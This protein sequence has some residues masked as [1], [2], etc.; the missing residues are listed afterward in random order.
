MT[1]DIYCYQE[2]TKG[3]YLIVKDIESQ[4]VADSFYSNKLD[5]VGLR[6]GNI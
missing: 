4:T 6:K 3:S 2:E 5:P 1:F